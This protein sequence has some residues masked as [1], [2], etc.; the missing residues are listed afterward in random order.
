MMSG[1]VISWKMRQSLCAGQHHIEGTRVA[2]CSGRRFLHLL[3]PSSGVDPACENELIT[4][5]M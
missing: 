1:T 3:P 5:L 2:G 4:P